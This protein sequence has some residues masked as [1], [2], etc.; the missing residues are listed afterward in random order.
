MRTPKE[1]LQSE[2]FDYVV[3]T[4]S[5]EIAQNE[6]TEQ[7]ALFFQA[8][9]RLAPK[10]NSANLWKTIKLFCWWLLGNFKHDCQQIL[11]SSLA[12][13]R[14]YPQSR[15]FQKLLAKTAKKSRRHDILREIYHLL[16]WEKLSHGEQLKLCH[17]LLEIREFDNVASVAK[18]ILKAHPEDREAQHLLWSAAAEI[19][20][21]NGS[22][23][24]FSMKITSDSKKE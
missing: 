4:L 19:S 13:L 8:L 6:K 23:G 10:D 11:E 22:A 18:M 7:T 12:L 24:D 16:G 9:A 3:H 1:A 17:I 20:D 14:L 21:P 15:F 2:K 5:R